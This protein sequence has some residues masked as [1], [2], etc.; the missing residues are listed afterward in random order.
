MLLTSAAKLLIF[1]FFFQ[2]SKFPKHSSKFL[3]LQYDLHG[4]KVET[5]NGVWQ[6]VGLTRLTLVANNFG[7]IW[8]PVP[9]M[10]FLN[11]FI[12]KLFQNFTIIFDYDE[13][14]RVLNQYEYQVSLGNTI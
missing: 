11:Y 14:S 13:F 4:E 6:S 12:Y 3:N 5:K 1:S 8:L 10:K 7:V 9:I 2:I